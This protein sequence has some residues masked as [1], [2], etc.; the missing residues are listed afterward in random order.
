MLF[1]ASRHRALRFLD[2]QFETSTAQRSSLVSTQSLV[3]LGLAW[4]GSARLGSVRF[5][6]ARLFF[7]F[8]RTHCASA[9]PRGYFLT[10]IL[11]RGKTKQNRTNPFLGLVNTPSIFVFYT[12]IDLLIA[13]PHPPR[14][15]LQKHAERC[16][17]S[18]IKID[19]GSNESCDWIFLFF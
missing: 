1:R 15:N 8:G 12:L 19:R 13:C 18:S 16:A 6:L 3:R 9:A 14:S 5:G 11:F 4:F 2:N 7:G 17:D 10:S